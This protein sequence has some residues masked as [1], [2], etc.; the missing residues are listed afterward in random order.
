MT[1]KDLKDLG[2]EKVEYEHYYNYVK[3]DMTSC[4]SDQHKNGQWY[5]MYEFPNS[6]GVVTNR[7][8]LKQLVYKLDERDN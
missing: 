1:E 4:D 2:F 5:V 6:R 3:G 8:L 7:S